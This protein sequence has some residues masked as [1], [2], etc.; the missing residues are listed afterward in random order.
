[1]LLEA[2]RDCFERQ[3]QQITRFARSLRKTIYWTGNKTNFSLRSKH[4]KHIGA[5][6]VSRGL[7]ENALRK[8]ETFDAYQIQPF[9]E[10]PGIANLIYLREA[11]FQQFL[12]FFEL[13]RL[14]LKSLHNFI[15]QKLHDSL[16]MTCETK[17]CLVQSKSTADPSWKIQKQNFSLSEK[18]SEYEKKTLTSTV[19]YWY[20]EAKSC[21]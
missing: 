9:S 21:R 13:E 2:Q 10:K 3:A 15:L 6:S 14:D 17:N 18:L 19:E 16:C 12:T 8:R 4:Q 5:M 1:M 11:F 7:Q 20:Y